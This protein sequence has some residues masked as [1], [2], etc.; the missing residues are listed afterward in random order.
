MF[1][2]DQMTEPDLGC[3]LGQI[4]MA[5]YG[6]QEPRV[7]AAAFEVPDNFEQTRGEWLV[8]LLLVEQV[9]DLGQA[10]PF[11]GAQAAATAARQTEQQLGLLR[12]MAYFIANGGR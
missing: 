4:Q 9:D 10:E 8:R 11:L 2:R 12:Y 6:S 3:S 5:Q 1:T 7:I